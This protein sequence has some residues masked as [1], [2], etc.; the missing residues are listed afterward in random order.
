MQKVI[1][2]IQKAQDWTINKLRGLF[3]AEQN[4][5]LLLAMIIGLYAGLAVVCFRIAIDWTRLWLLAC[6]FSVPP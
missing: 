4:L 6:G 1:A 5:F 2:R 3:L